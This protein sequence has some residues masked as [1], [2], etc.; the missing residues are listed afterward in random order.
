VR[1]LVIAGHSTAALAARQSQRG[2]VYG[3]RLKADVSANAF[4]SLLKSITRAKRGQEDRQPCGN[5]ACPLK[6]CLVMP[7]QMPEKTAAFIEAECLRVAKLQLG[8]SDLT[9]VRI[10]RTKPRGS[11]PNWE[12]FGFKPDLP[13]QA[14]EMAMTAI[15]KLRQ[16][17]A[18]ALKAES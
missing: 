18:L 4:A 11:G 5:R 14:Q 1:Y 8:C 15:A 3:K 10:G 13:Q 12:V 7:K 2:A 9:A 17:Y 6:S 16:T